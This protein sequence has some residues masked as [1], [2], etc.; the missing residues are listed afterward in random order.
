MGDRKKEQGPK[1]A[2]QLIEAALVAADLFHDENGDTFATVDFEARKTTLRV[3]S[4]SMREWI[5]LL[6]REIIGR[7]PGES[8]VSEAI[9][10]LSAT[11]R[12]ERPEH[13]VFVRVAY[14]D[15]SIY[16]DLADDAGRV[17]HVTSEGW[18]V[19]TSSLV[20]FYR[21][22]AM[23]PLPV[24]TL[25]GSI[26]PLRCL[27]NVKS[28]RDLYLI[29]GWMLMALRPGAP[30]PVLVLTGEQ[31][32]CKSSAARTTRAMVD[33]NRALLRTA[34][35][36]EDDLGVCCMHSHVVAFDNL[37]GLPPWLSDALCGVCTGSGIAKRTLYSD[38]DE[39][40]L[41]YQRPIIL[42]G[43]DAM[44]TRADLAE[45]SIVIELAPIP[46]RARLTERDI[47]D[48]LDAAAPTVLAALL[49]GISSAIENQTAVRMSG[50]PRMADFAT[51]VT[52]AE[53]GL[54]LPMG[55]FM[56]AYSDAT[57]ATN[58]TIVSNDDVAR[59]LIAFT[60]WEGTPS[61][62]L[63]KLRREID[64]GPKD[65]AFPVNA[66]ALTR[67]LRRIAPVLRK[68][69]VAI[70]M[71]K[72]NH[73]RFVTLAFTA[74]AEAGDDGDDIEKVI[75]H[76]NRFKTRDGDDGDDRDAIP[77]TRSVG[78]MGSAKTCSSVRW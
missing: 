21:P 50:L 69:G 11:A 59:T 77:R 1:I 75:V 45:R 70:D 49:D 30:C 31:G 35:R 44:A 17:V 56:R 4:G 6:G 32:S 42:N 10:I 40:V 23:R 65:R 72:A 3:R 29:V 8:A 57:E 51:W 64:P 15:N 36:T 39:T 68:S 60:P 12:F 46:A 5:S 76:Q 22:K 7:V 74:T 67:R 24:P 2:D 63:T 62:L 13:P 9:E 55:T 47:A 38:A 48:R 58:E 78:T 16:L 33:P 41:S 28:D 26:A 34:P 53:P 20:R 19:S 61:A 27:L 37:S 66:A 25:P 71:G 52:A 43:I 14:V 54:G 73:E 18:R